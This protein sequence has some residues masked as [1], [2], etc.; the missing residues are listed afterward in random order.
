MGSGRTANVIVNPLGQN[1]TLDQVVDLN[2]PQLKQMSGQSAP[3]KVSKIQ[4]PAGEVAKI[5]SILESGNMHGI[6]STGYYAVKGQTLV[7]VTFSAMSKDAAD[8][9]AMAEKSMQTFRFE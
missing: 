4:T 1:M 2:L 9:A 8:V 5:E 7:V 3:P 6:A